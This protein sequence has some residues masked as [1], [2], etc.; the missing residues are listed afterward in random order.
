MPVD[1][2]EVEACRV[3][4]DQPKEESE[5]QFPMHACL[6]LPVSLKKKRGEKSRWIIPQSN[7]DVKGRLV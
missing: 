1:Y 5:V 6:I 2:G 7:C 4:G 3:K